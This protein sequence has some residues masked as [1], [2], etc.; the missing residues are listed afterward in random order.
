MELIFYEEIE[1][2]Q[3]MKLALEN[4]YIGPRKGDSSRKW[5]GMELGF[6]RVTAQSVFYPF[7]IYAFSKYR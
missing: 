2:D 7:F 3:E 6:T 4:W 1:L 5:S